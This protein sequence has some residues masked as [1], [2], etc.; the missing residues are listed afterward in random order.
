MLTSVVIRIKEV[1]VKPRTSLY[2][3][4]VCFFVYCLEE[5]K[6]TLTLSVP[7]KLIESTP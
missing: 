6:E 3:F 7:L 2:W 1:G 4:S 5:G